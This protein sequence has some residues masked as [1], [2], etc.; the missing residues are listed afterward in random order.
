LE[1]AQMVLQKL[2]DLGYDN[3]LDIILQ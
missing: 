2:C 1:E 3:I